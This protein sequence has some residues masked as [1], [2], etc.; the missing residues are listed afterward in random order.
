ME[1]GS[2]SA[3]KWVVAAVVLSLVVILSAPA[4]LQALAGSVTL[5]E[6]QPELPDVPD[7]T[8]AEPRAPVEDGTAVAGADYLVVDGSVTS[9]DDAALTVEGPAQAM[10][11]AFPVIEGDEAC[12]ATVMLEI[13][14][15]DTDGEGQIGV[16]PSGVFT[17]LQLVDGDG[18]VALLTQSPAAIAVTDGS[19]GRLRW[20][21][22]DLYRTW[23]RGSAFGD[24]TIPGGVPFT[25]A[26]RGVDD[27]GGFTFAALEAGE[28]Q[29]PAIVWTGAPEC[30]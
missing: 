3:L 30:G 20:D 19:L 17:P 9:S 2:G 10:V 7:A 28:T 5:E 21:V 26:I 22:T 29:A 4:A 25:V 18:A 23:V 12:I 14:L 6:S 13:S 27:G 8:A 11:A 15:T 1:E 16:Y 24:I